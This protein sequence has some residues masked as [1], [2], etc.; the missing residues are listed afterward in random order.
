MLVGSATFWAARTTPRA[1]KQSDPELECGQQTLSELWEDAFRQYRITTGVNLKDTDSVLYRRLKD[2]F[3]CD[4]VVDVLVEAA[5]DFGLYRHPSAGRVYEDIRRALKP[6]VRAVL[7]AGAL[8]AGGELASAFTL[9][10]GKA[11]FVAVMVLLRAT[12]GVSARF[13]DVLRLLERFRYYMQ[14]LRIREDMPMEPEMR[15][16]VVGILVKMIH[17]FAIVTKTMQKNRFE[18]FMSVLGGTKNA[19]FDAARE[20][21]MLETQDTR[22]ILASVYKEVYAYSHIAHES[23]LADVKDVKDRVAQV[24]DRLDT[25]S[26]QM[27]DMSI[28]MQYSAPASVASNA[29]S[30]NVATLPV[31]A[32]VQTVGTAEIW[33]LC[34]AVTYNNTVASTK[35]LSGSI[36]STLKEASDHDRA[37]LEKGLVILYSIAACIA[38]ANI[39]ISTSAAISNPRVFAVTFLPMAMTYLAAILCLRNLPRNPGHT[40]TIVIIDVVGD[41]A[42]VPLEEYSSWADIH[43]L[44]LRRFIDKPGATFVSSGDYRIMDTAGE[45]AIITPTTWAQNVKAG[46]ILEMGIIIRQTSS[47]LR[48]PYCDFFASQTLDADEFLRCKKCKR[49]Y[50]ASS[51]LSAEVTDIDEPATSSPLTGNDPSTD[52]IISEATDLSAPTNIPNLTLAGSANHGGS[53]HDGE[54]AVEGEESPHT[55]DMT[56]FRRI[57][58]EVLP[59]TH[60]TSYDKS[61]ES[62]GLSTMADSD[63]FQAHGVPRDLFTNPSYPSH[64][65]KAAVNRMRESIIAQNAGPQA[66]QSQLAQLQAMQ[67]QHANRRAPSRQQAPGPGQLP[68]P[69][70]PGL[71]HASPMPQ[72]VNVNPQQAPPQQPDGPQAGGGMTRDNLAARLRN[73]PPCQEEMFPRAW[74]AWMKQGGVALSM[75]DIQPPEVL[76]GKP[77]ISLWRLHALHHASHLREFEMWYFQISRARIMQSQGQQN[78]QAARMAPERVTQAMQ[79]AAMG[80]SAE[81]LKAR[82]V[83]DDVIQF[84]EANREVLLAKHREE[85][86]FKQGLQQQ[87]GQQPNIALHPQQ[88]P[89]MRG[90]IGQP[91]QPHVNGGGVGGPG[92]VHAPPPLPL[93]GQPPQLFGPVPAARDLKGVRPDGSI[94]LVFILAAQEYIIKMK[95]SIE[96]QLLRE[97]NDV[98]PP[99]DADRNEWMALL[100]RV[101]GLAAEIDQTLPTFIAYIQGPNQEREPFFRKYLGDMLTVAFQKRLVLQSEPRFIV[102]QNTLLG[103]LQLFSNFLVIIHNRTAAVRLELKQLHGFAP[104]VPAEYLASDPSSSSP[105]LKR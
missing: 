64:E 61:Q 69:A 27:A 23:L 53:A 51:A 42:L 28:R 7:S 79:A 85:T 76:Q 29:A 13:D 82:G 77:S 4:A 104:N 8:E 63:W 91:G 67:G 52:D 9:H 2:C 68:N 17:T 35:L 18:H 44:L 21:E 87:Q 78:Q 30:T 32:N 33:R 89:Y 103:Y 40:C 101:S 70:T 43:A 80:V 96:P 100:E 74:H 62:G 105:T 95:D 94:D 15:S 86:A 45:S 88:P 83:G 34:L 47:L 92:N 38:G 49:Q 19:A 90:G 10:G 41:H 36:L 59:D 66:T 48:C 56:L 60:H 46:M 24:Q 72:P 55:G 75:D 3:G 25:M 22:L 14:R 93:Q 58:V 12:Q 73:L 81:E 98:D 11:P 97:I 50:R 1:V 57:L 26:W 99:V 37:N 20:L 31:C 102:D 16:V 39:D 71:P 54:S 65:V 84:V 5:Q 6:I